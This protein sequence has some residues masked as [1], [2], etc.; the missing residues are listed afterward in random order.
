MDMIL[1]AGAAVKLDCLL[2]RRMDLFQIQMSFDIKKLWASIIPSRIKPDDDTFYFVKQEY[3][4]KH[5]VY[6]GPIKSKFDG[7]WHYITGPQLIK[8]YK[9]NPKEVIIAETS[10]GNLRGLDLSQFNHFYPRWDGDYTC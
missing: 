3:S 9:L 1:A 10:Q 8:L 6:P 4:K 2:L 7:D 5:I